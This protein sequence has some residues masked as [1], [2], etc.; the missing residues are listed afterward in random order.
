MQSTATRYLD[1]QLTAP[2]PIP[3]KFQGNNALFTIGLVGD[4]HGA[5]QHNLGDVSRIWRLDNEF[6]AVA[7]GSGHGSDD[8][9]RSPEQIGRTEDL[10]GVFYAET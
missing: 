2:I 7:D 3:I 9:P 10:D 8:R 4:R 6:L 5:H 1:S